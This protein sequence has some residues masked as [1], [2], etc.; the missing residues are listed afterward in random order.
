M[1]DTHVTGQIGLN[2]SL[3]FVFGILF[4]NHDAPINVQEPT[5][6]NGNSLA[7][8]SPMSGTTGHPR[9]LESFPVTAEKIA[10][11]LR[12]VSAHL[13]SVKLKLSGH[14]PEC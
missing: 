1:H 14:I 6:F 2:M 13:D 10:L 4:L 11:V 3:F 9:L 8:D 5:R 12:M 7:N